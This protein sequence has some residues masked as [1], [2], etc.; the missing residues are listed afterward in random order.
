MYD[1]YL[2]IASEKL[3]KA[4]KNLEERFMTIRAGRANPAMLDGVMVSYYGALTPV[5]QLAT[6]FVPEARQI[7]IKPFDR[8]ALGA[9]EK[10]IFEANLGVTPNNNGEVIFINIPPLTEER[11]RDLVKQAKEYAE[12][13]RIAVRNIRK[14]I[15]DDIKKGEL[16]ED[17][18]KSL[19]D[20][21][22]DI[23]VDYNKKIEEL[24]KLKEKDLMEF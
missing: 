2:L 22:Q 9:I 21:L 6:I 3:D 11:R 17:E 5:K 12:D 14:D 19:L 4:I 7:S 13:G 18:E 1:E 20:D 15:I 16:P 24:L 10:A 8:T 23:I